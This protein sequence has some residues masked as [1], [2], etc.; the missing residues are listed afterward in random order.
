MGTLV[1]MSTTEVQPT[2]EIAALLKERLGELINE[3]PPVSQ[4]DLALKIRVPT[5]V[6]NRA[7]NGTATPQAAAL[8]AIAEY[9]GVTTDWL[10]GIEG[11]PKKRRRP[12][13]T[14]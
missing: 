11:A 12:L 10:L 14:R 4:R 6:L 3:N 7:I 2:P 1:N 9:Y 13:A 8:K 5:M